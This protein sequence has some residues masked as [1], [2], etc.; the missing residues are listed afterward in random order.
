MLVY[1][2]GL[3]FLV[4]TDVLVLQ[5]SSI[6]AR[7]GLFTVL[8]STLL[9][10]LS[11]LRHETIGGRDVYI[12]YKANFHYTAELDWGTVLGRLFSIQEI[13]GDGQE[14][15]YTVFIRLV[16]A[17]GGDYRAFLF[18]MALAFVVPLGWVIYRWSQD[19]FLS[20]VVYYVV[21]FSFFSLTGFR[22]TLA[23]SIVVL[24]GYSS[25]KFRKPFRFLALIG[26]AF[27]FHRSAVLYALVYPATA[28]KFVQNP[29]VVAVTVLSV[30]AVLRFAP[31]AAL[32][33]VTE[34]L[35]YEGYLDNDFG[36]TETFTLLILLVFL[37]SLWRWTRTLDA[38]PSAFVN[39]GAIAP[40]T[41]FAT[42]TLYNQSFMRAQQYFSLLLVLLI[43]NLVASFSE[44][45]RVWIR[46]ALTM[47]LG[48]LLVR[49]APHYLFYWHSP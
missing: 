12:T 24:I 29:R 49:N 15:G 44:K 30:L 17:V 1:L 35:G 10:L 31:E 18:I 48:L 20:F 6:R 32:G 5:N 22:Q 34:W 16:S 21:F 2:L 33:P 11:G 25:V 41:L 45:D 9:V 3:G 13:T 46:F 43:P 28:A 23:T 37:V 7:R 27:L 47:L 40:A 36:G 39:L 19:P 8:A 4:V 26:L 42:L 38:A 14:P